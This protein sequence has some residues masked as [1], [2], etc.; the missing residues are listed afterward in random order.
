MCFRSL[1]KF[2][3]TPDGQKKLKEATLSIIANFLFLDK[4]ILL[5]IFR[6]MDESGDGKLGIEEL[7]FGFKEILGGEEGFKTNADL[8]SIMDN[9]DQD[10]NDFI[11]YSDFLIASIDYSEDSFLK[12]C[13]I[14]YE[15]YFDNSQESIDV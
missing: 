14:A 7:K 11:D 5:N 3:K 9:V 4:P 1:A 10:G 6:I 15:K 8:Q 12:Y 2:K 13:E